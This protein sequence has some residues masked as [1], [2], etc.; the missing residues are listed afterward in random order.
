MIYSEKLGDRGGS[1]WWD[2]N[3][4]SPLGRGG[5]KTPGLRVGAASSQREESPR[6]HVS[7]G[8]TSP[9]AA[10]LPPDLLPAIHP[11]ELA[12]RDRF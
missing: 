10:P 1:E 2:W 8:S 7:S 3:P 12:C 4:P 9:P 5:A 11:L 6:A